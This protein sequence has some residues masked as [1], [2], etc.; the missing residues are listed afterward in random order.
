VLDED[1]SLT[2]AVKRLT[3]D[4]AL[5][6]RV[7]SNADEYWRANHTVAHMV[8]DYESVLAELQR[9][10]AARPT[11]RVYDSRELPGHLRPDGLEYTRALLAPFGDAVNSPLD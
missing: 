3:M 1:H 9:S 6:E 7:A 11:P 8:A 2:L 10:S 5:R 4:R